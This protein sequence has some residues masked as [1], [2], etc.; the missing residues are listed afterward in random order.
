MIIA[1]VALGALSALL[2]GILITSA[3]LQ[4]GFD[5]PRILSGEGIGIVGPLIGAVIARRAGFINSE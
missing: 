4:A 2:G 3:F 1:G 5:I